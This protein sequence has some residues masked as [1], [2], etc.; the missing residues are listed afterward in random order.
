MLNLLTKIDLS[1]SIEILW[2]GMLAI[3]VAMGVICLFTWFL[4]FL[5]N[6]K[7]FNKKKK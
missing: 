7:M 1:L 4:N 3:F 6:S 5:A 2:K